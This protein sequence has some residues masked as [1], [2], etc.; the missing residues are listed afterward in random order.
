M[1]DGWFWWFSTWHMLVN[2]QWSFMDSD[3][4]L[5]GRGN[6]LWFRLVIKLLN[7]TFSPWMS[8]CATTLHCMDLQDM[9]ACSFIRILLLL[10]T[11]LPLLF[12]YWLCPVLCQCFIAPNF[13]AWTAEICLPPTQPPELNLLTTLRYQYSYLATIFRVVYN[14]MNCP[15]EFGA[16][17]APRQMC[18]DLVCGDF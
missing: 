1:V 7:K 3:Q 13:L 15:A 12:R 16:Y 8:L 14:L 4:V 5:G 18:A 6:F 11:L 2:G 9:S 17:V 10:H